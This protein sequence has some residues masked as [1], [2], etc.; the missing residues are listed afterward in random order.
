METTLVKTQK[1]LLLVAGALLIL[2][3]TFIMIRRM[4]VRR[5]A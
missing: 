2:V 1:A 3:G 5:A 4:P